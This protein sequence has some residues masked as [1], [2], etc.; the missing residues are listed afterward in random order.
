MPDRGTS[1]KLVDSQT[2]TRPKERQRGR[3][4]RVL[5]LAVGLLAGLP[6]GASSAEGGG[7]K[8]IINGQPGPRLSSGTLSEN[9]GPRQLTT[10]RDS[11]GGVS[12]NT[13][14][15]T[16]AATL[17]QLIGI[18]PSSVQQLQVGGVSLERDEIV[19]GFE[20][21]TKGTRF[22]TFDASSGRV[23]F[24]RPL[25]DIPGDAN[26]QDRISAQ[27]GTDLEVNVFTNAAPL[28]VTS[29]SDRMRASAGADVRFR[30]SA[31]GDG[32]H[33]YFWDFGD[34]TVGDG[35]SPA[36]AFASAGLYDVVV[37]VTTPRGGS[38][39]AVPLQIR[40]GQA[41]TGGT[42]TTPSGAAAPA[43]GGSGGSGT[44]GGQQGSGGGTGGA[45]AASSG[46]AKGT[47]GS[48]QS[49]AAAA[50]RREKKE[51]AAREAARA[52][53]ASPTVAKPIPKDS[54]PVGDLVRGTLVA[55]SSAV[56]PE[57]L[58]AAEALARVPER[59]RTPARAAAGD[60]SSAL[61]Q[62]AGGA[63]LL[64]LLVVGAMREGLRP[65]QRLLVPT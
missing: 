38:G 37:T 51:K 33:F 36:H 11:A 12:R 15:G 59:S 58:A 53:A 25:R 17:V 8:M 20:G 41:N 7:V 28:N 19:N 4:S 54:G 18:N 45:D 5:L 46:P 60:A 22:A 61:A 27:S 43:G 29:S 24:F 1:D 10:T 64:A 30:A 44:G 62:A 39:V 2:V 49:A 50:R 3:A 40:V 63:L 65:S 35:P 48:G 26:N 42:A 6:A 52:E 57:V 34:G 21:D 14:G 31:D 13:V 32:R 55:D 23:V 9:Q 16:P 56:S 47:Q